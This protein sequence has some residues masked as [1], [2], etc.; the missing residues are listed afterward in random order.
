[1]IVRII[2]SFSTIMGATAHMRHEG[3]PLS[4]ILFSLLE[5]FLTFVIL[6]ALAFGFLWLCSAL[7]D[8]NK[9]QETDSP[10]YRSLVYHYSRALID[11]LSI[12]IH[13]EGLEKLPKEGRFLL[14]CNHQH[15]ADPG[16][17]MYYMRHSQ[18]VFISKQE[19]KDMFIMGKLMHKLRAQF[20]NRENDRQGLKVILNCIDLIK[21]DEASIA[22]LPEGGIKIEGKLSPFRPG[23]F[24]IATKANVPIV[25]CTIR[26]TQFV[27]RQGLK[28]KPTDVHFH[29][30]DVIQPEAFAGKKTTEISE[31]VHKMM[32]DDLGE[33]FRLEEPELVH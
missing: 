19:S 20:I 9:A 11:L 23:V 1:M 26:N 21:R 6:S 5:F 24:K 29:V 27:L 22:V 4:W 2:L 15:E 17:I 18:L 12:R 32:A 13:T 8:F 31:M 14:V 16:I 10:F 28:L 33:E 7:V 3:G 25:V 30:L